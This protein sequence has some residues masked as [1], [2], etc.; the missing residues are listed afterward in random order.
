MIINS[1]NFSF[2]DDNQSAIFTYRMCG[3]SVGFMHF[4]RL[5]EKNATEIA[6]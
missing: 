1:T 2:F 3:D 6:L 4:A 5:P